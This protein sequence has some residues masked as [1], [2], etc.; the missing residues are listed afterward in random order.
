MQPKAVDPSL[1]ATEASPT[2]P[3]ETGAAVDTER[4]VEAPPAED[5]APLNVS[6]P[7]AAVGMD[8]ESLYE[9][10]KEVDPAMAARLHPNN[11]RKI[12]R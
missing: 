2:P 11:T 9:R 7:S 6:A 3:S 1:F 10:L 8:G 5:K 12:Q 4:H